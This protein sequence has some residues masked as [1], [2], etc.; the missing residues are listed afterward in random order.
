MKLVVRILS[1]VL[2]AVI[3]ATVAI[4]CV[5]PGSGTEKL[6]QLEDLLMTRFIGEAEEKKLED[7]A[8]SAMVDALGDRWSYYMTAEDYQS[9]LEIMSNSYVGVGITITPNPDGLGYDIIEVTPNAPAQTAGVAVGDILIAVDGKSVVDMNNSELGTLVR[10]EE[11]TSVKLT[12][13]RGNETLEFTVVRKKF[14]TPV[15]TSAMLEN[16]IGLI[17]IENF[18][19]RCA[20]ETI[21][22]IKSVTEQGAK[23]L[24]FDVR[25]NPGGYKDELV[26]VLDY[27]LPEGEV[28]R[29]EDYLGRESVDYSDG[30]FVDMPMAVL[31]NLHSYSAAEFFAAALMEYDAAV[32]VGEKTYGKGYFQTTYALKDGSAVNLSIGKYYTPKGNS[33]A[34]VG[35]QPDVEEIVDAET[36]AA[37][38][39]GTLEP[40]QDPQIQAAIAALSHNF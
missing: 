17:T 33:L 40:S 19:A 39:A 27:L 1:Y 26:K 34:G 38:S 24:L 11:G 4:A 3:A 25:N 10:G 21:A 2:V 5:L 29:T 18:D 15:A 6:T 20:E 36:A 30:D 9:Y 14:Q 12:V 22:A 8:A 7:A 32:V 35:I 28:F 31:V 23:A 13:Q 16:N 37:I